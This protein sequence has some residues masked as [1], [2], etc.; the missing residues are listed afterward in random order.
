MSGGLHG[1]GVSVVNALAEWLE[2]TVHRDDKKYAQ[3]YFRGEPKKLIH[4]LLL[5]SVKKAA[6]L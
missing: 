2:I 1:V 4:L 5:E 3:Q 6:F